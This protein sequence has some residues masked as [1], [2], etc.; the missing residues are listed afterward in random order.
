MDSL[1]ILKQVYGY[2]SFRPGQE[3]LV[4]ALLEG[5][6]ALGIMPTGAGKSVCYQ[7]PALMRPGTALVISP[8]ISLMKDQV[9]ALVANGV[10]AA[11]LN[12]SLTPRQM[13][14]ALERAREGR[15]R[16]IYV[17]PERLD[18]AAFRSLAQSREISLI[19]VDEAHCVS[20]WGQDFRP[21]YLRIADFIASLPQ[22]PPVG[23]FTATAT[24]RV[25]QDIVR[26]LGLQAPVTEITGFDRP[27]LFFHVQPVTR[28]RNDV[29][30]TLLSELQGQNGIIYCA[31]RK[32]VEMVCNKLVE[33]GYPA[34]RYHAGLEEAERRENQEAFQYDRASVMVAT[35]A[36]GMGID[37]SN[38]N[39]VIHYNMPKSVEE[40]YQEAG[41]AGRDGEPAVCTILY[42]KSDIITNRQL[43]LS[44]EPNPELTPEERQAVRSRDLERLQ[45]MIRYCESAGCLRES[46]LRYFG[47]PMRTPCTGCAVCAPGRFPE[48]AA[49]AEGRKS[50]PRSGS[51]GKAKSEKPETVTQADSDLYEK[52]RATR[53]EIARARNVPAYVICHDSTLR[54]MAALRPRTR[55][56]LLAVYG[57]GERK[58]ADI[59]PAFLAVIGGEAAET[60]PT[61]PA[62]EPPQPAAPEPRQ[63]TAPDGGRLHHK[64]AAAWQ[65]GQSSADIAK[66]FGITRGEVLETLEDLGML[67]GGT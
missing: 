41:R 7:V 54:S 17:A 44:G 4:N 49:V 36:F 57:M 56:S 16:V 8:L 50:A 29:L 35:N 59:G 63:E 31:T 39:F 1:S 21:S 34:V 14:L 48:T 58:A 22:R 6:D 28:G 9:G 45:A 66:V 25:R 27:N 55:E 13:D 38:V 60:P 24:A 3:A 33:R 62:P 40:Y 53:L 51:A 23:A 43:I 47:Q 64:I 10:P 61:D 42:A 67:R 65:A 11:Y 2:D 19:A 52:L 32:N 37:K 30:L 20:Q 5:W 15:Y 26:L 18:T 12:S 46:I